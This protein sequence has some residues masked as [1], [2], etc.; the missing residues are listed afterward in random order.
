MT[1]FPIFR[2]PGISSSSSAENGEAFLLPNQLRIGKLTVSPP[3]FLAPM[4]GVTHTALRQL[5]AS[6][7]GCGCFYTEMLNAVSLPHEHPRRSFFLSRSTAENPLVYQIM[8]GKAEDIPPAVEVLHACGAD[9]VDLNMGCA[10][11]TILK[12]GA[13]VALMRDPHRSRQLVSVLRR[14]TDLPLL[15]KLR[16]GWEADAPYLIRFC[17]L[18][19]D[20]GADAVVLHARLA[21][22]RFKR[23]VKPHFIT[24]VKQ[25]L[26]IPV[27]GNGDIVDVET[28]SEMFRNTGCDGIMIGRAA[29]SRPWIFRDIS[30][31]LWNR[32]EIPD[33][34]DPR[35]VFDRYV[36]LLKAHFPPERQ[37]G[38]L[39][40]FTSYFAGS[41]FFGHTLWKKV[42]GAQSVDEAW[43]RAS[44]FL[45]SLKE[46]PHCGYRPRLPRELGCCG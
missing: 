33:P 9:A 30:E 40:E 22:D 43:E 12:Q 16:I 13:G 42:Q 29:V 1:D 20:A 32:R 45:D 28:A 31:M 23:P 7:G 15:V 18:M 25:A 10:A 6:F 39:K 14:S 37:L 4:A 5:I 26:A 41:F 27:I 36:T 46:Q 3:V 34:P 8:T 35:Q 21:E 38:R 2:Q 44:L 17:R 24:A 19:E 11:P